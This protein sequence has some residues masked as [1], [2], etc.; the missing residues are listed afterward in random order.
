MTDMKTKFLING[1][2]ISIVRLSNE[3]AL[4]KLPPKNLQSSA[5]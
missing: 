2:T 5:Q 1:N 3:T 4:D